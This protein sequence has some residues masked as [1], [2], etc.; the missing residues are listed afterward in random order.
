MRNLNKDDVKRRLNERALDV[1]SYLYP[2]GKKIGNDW[3]IGD[4]SGELG[5]SLKI[6]IEGQNAGLW[7]DH[8]NGEK[9][10][11]IGLWEAAHGV[12]FP[13]AIE[14][15]SEWLGVARPKPK[16]KPKVNPEKKRPIRRIP[17]DTPNK[18]HYVYVDENGDPFAFVQ[19]TTKS[20]GGKTFAAWG[21]GPG[22]EGWVCSLQNLSDKRLLYRLPSIVATESESIF[23]HEGE[24][25]VD[26]A[27]AAGLAGIHTTTMG[28]AQSPQHTDFSSLKGRTVVIV[29]DNDEPGD[30]YVQ[31]LFHLLLEAGTSDVSVLKLPDLPPKGDIVEWL[32]N[33]G[34][35]EKW[36]GLAATAL[37][38]VEIPKKIEGKTDSKETEAEGSRMDPAKLILMLVQSMAELFHD[39]S[40]DTFASIKQ[41]GHCETWPIGSK[42]F[43]EWMCLIA[44]RNHG[45]VPSE[46]LTKSCLSTLS[47]I[48][49]F[50]GPEIE[51]HVRS[52][53]Y[54][55][56]YLIDLTDAQWRA[57]HITQDG[58]QVVDKPELRFIRSPNSLPLPLP[59]SGHIDALWR[60]VN[61]PEEWKTLFL[62]FLLECFRPD[63]PYLAMQ[64]TGEQGSAKSSTHRTIRNLVDP[65]KVPFRSPPKEV[66]DLY[67]SAKHSL[68][69]SLENI[70]GLSDRLQDAF[71]VLCT[72]GGYAA[73]KLYTNDEESII[74]VRRPSVING[75][76]NVVL[77][78]D[79][80]DRTI[81]FDLDRIK[82]YREERVI[83]E[84]FKKEWP[85][86]VGALFDIFAKTLS[87][88]GNVR[89]NSPPR[90]VDF[91][92]LGEA[93]HK[94]LGRE[95]SFQEIY[96][97]NRSEALAQAIDA[98]P[99]AAAVLSMMRYSS[100]W[101]GTVKQLLCT[102][103]PPGPTPEGWPKSVRGFSGILRRLAPALRELGV[104]VEFLN[105]ERD[106]RKLRITSTVK[107]WKPDTTDTTD[108]ELVS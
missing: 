94:A 6:C 7:I 30:K 17:K 33:G 51:V 42:G 2:N 102:V 68:L 57:V 11:L 71:C 41:N 3:A 90:M 93:M 83:A 78:P 25:A 27:V 98:S 77:R 52:A 101:H 81:H 80:I 48:A 99:S 105:R 60:F 84:E 39:S 31:K 62:A 34:G 1:V 108:T 44:Y 92:R 74:D 40:G 45:I 14:E 23:I 85:G 79:L 46:N 91:A 4:T 5:Q 86:I 107:N 37:E 35:T 13:A 19:R 88:L 8:A 56:G 18:R 50:D 70:S 9:G 29:P 59:Q 100:E 87:E 67:V 55:G 16:R 61:I 12:D 53:T 66:Q 49:K 82:H 28:G 36:K 73:R 43:R 97:R 72:G 75:I 10:D 65:N 24:K 63:T 15:A 89:L 32:E 54:K 103:T 69:V 96:M 104:E 38:P 47:G 106:G 64:L 20:D 22:G 26:A 58:Y 95:D 76:S 21:P